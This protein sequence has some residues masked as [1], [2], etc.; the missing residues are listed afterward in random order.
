MKKSTEFPI[1]VGMDVSKASLEVAVRP[2]GETCKVNNDLQGIDWLVEEMRKISPT[3]IILEATGGYEAACA[4][5]LKV[6]GRR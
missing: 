5:A 1:Y 3:L 6:A 4:T 2:T